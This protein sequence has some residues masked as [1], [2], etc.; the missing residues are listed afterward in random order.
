MPN[1][2]LEVEQFRSAADFLREVGPW[3]LASEA[4]NS[5]L[6]SIVHLLAGGDH[7]FQEPFYLTAIKRAGRVVGCAVRPP[8]D[9]LDL[10]ALPAGAV[11]LLIGGVAALYPQLHMVAGPPDSALEFA[12]AWT[13]RARRPLAGS[14]QVDAA[15]GA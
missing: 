8:P 1:A 14:V 6:L 15:R 9:Q 2:P 3:L 7:P 12:N 10:T 4:D 13:R 11:E 5:V